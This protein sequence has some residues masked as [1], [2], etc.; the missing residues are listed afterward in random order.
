MNINDDKNNISNNKNCNQNNKL[1]NSNN[2]NK[3]K[4]VIQIEEN[5]DTTPSTPS[6]ITTLNEI[7]CDNE[8]PKKTITIVTETTPINL[9]PTA[10]RSSAS[11]SSGNFLT[12]GSGF[13]PVTPSSA[14]KQHD[15]R[16]RRPSI[17]DFVS[18]EDST[19][20]SENELLVH[21]TNPNRYDMSAD[22]MSDNGNMSVSQYA[23]S[24]YSNINGK[25]IDC[26]FFQFFYKFIRF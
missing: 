23:L 6:T 24:K 1:S 25:S 5:V 20:D 10:L 9:Q 22:S 14:S 2:N 15:D 19:F 21:S 3:P 12:I 8:Q 26:V 16:Q 17:F 11:S 13:K 18:E 7:N 4:I